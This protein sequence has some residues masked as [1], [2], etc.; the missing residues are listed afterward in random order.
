MKL[1]KGKLL[2]RV[3]DAPVPV[4]GVDDPCRPEPPPELPRHP[5]VGDGLRRPAKAVYADPVVE[6]LAEDGVSL[7]EL[8]EPFE[9]SGDPQ[10]QRRCEA[11]QDRVAALDGLG[12]D[13]AG[14]EAKDGR[15][16]QRGYRRH[17]QVVGDVG[18]HA[19]NLRD[20]AHHPVAEVVVPDGLAPEP[21]VLGGAG[22]SLDGRV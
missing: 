6:A 18:R 5:A 19:R 9:V 10:Q 7:H 15:R 8:Q 17:R 3:V 20:G 16:R 22:V 1:K 21:Q 11:A 2:D 12:A 4:E 13:D 14:D